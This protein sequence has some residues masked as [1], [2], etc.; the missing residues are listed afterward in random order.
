MHLLRNEMAMT[1]GMII[2]VTHVSKLVSGHQVKMIM[3]TFLVMAKMIAFMVGRMRVHMAMGSD[4]DS[5]FTDHGSMR[6]VVVYVTGGM[7]IRM[8]VVDRVHERFR[9]NVWRMRV[10]LRIAQLWMGRA[11]V[12][13]IMSVMMGVCSGCVMVV[14]D[15]MVY[16][17]VYVVVDCCCVCCS[18]VMGRISRVMRIGARSWR[19][20]VV[21]LVM[22]GG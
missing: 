1:I 13:D 6:V 2:S 16:V 4:G 5:V 18:I 15:V 21:M 14:V 8:M 19:S 10:L 20:M 17:V 22:R 12:V 9:R 7:M 11:E 3:V